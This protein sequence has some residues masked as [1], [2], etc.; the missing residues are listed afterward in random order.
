MICVAAVM[1]CES[2]GARSTLNELCTCIMEEGG[3]MEEHP[4]LA[5]PPTPE[6][7]QTTFA[8]NSKETNK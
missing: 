3:I 7:S 2:T 6:N 4:G 1:I 8:S 5:T